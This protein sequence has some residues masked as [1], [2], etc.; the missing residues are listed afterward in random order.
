M[1]SKCNFKLD[2]S[3]LKDQERLPLGTYK[4]V[5]LVGQKGSGKSEMAKVLESLG[6]R[7]MSFADPLKAGLATMF[8]IPQAVFYD[9]LLKEVP[10]RE[11]S[12]VT[13][14]KMMQLLGTDFARNILG[15]DVWVSLMLKR[16]ARVIKENPKVLIVVDDVRFENEFELLTRMDA[17][18]INIR[19]GKKDSKQISLSRGGFWRFC[20]SLVSKF[21][22]PLKNLGY[23]W[24][25]RE[26]KFD[27]HES[28]NL[29][30]LMN[31][32]TVSVM[33][34]GDLEVL[35]EKVLDLWTAWGM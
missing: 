35:R 26:L 24:G 28:E 10:V 23:N 19:R 15:R 29:E 4:I 25:W 33:N 20:L 34:E 13:P 1:V 8:M 32:C 11:L 16:L 31:R 21:L 27:G 14:R 9:P 3:S 5:G 7:R 18:M 12:N 17:I 22:K 6:F 30:E 2:F